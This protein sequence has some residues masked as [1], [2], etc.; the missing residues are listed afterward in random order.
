MLAALYEYANPNLTDP[1]HDHK[2]VQATYNYL[3]AC[4]NLFES[5]TLSHSKINTPSG[6]EVM[7]NIRNGLE[8][9]TTWLKGLIGKFS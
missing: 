5:G 1:P 9:F 8:Y 3:K 7:E 4:N 6:G 2:E